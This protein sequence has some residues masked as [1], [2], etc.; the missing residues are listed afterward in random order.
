M[1][2]L[3]SVD[4]SARDANLQR[5]AFHPHCDVPRDDADEY[6]DQRN[7]IPVQIET[8]LPTKSSPIQTAAMNQ[9]S[10]NILSSYW[11][12]CGGSCR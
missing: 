12:A 5:S 6:L 3:S 2:K 1:M 10:C 9:M 8:K 4:V 11:S 7:E